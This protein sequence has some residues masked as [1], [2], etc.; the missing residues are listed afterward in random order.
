MNWK[1]SQHAHE[2]MEV[3]TIVIVYYRLLKV[4]VL[5]WNWCNQIIYTDYSLDVK[6]DSFEIKI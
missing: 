5:Y 3:I 6:Y 1:R 4:D 2:N